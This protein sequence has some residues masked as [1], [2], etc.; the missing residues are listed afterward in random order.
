MTG[1]RLL[2]FLAQWESLFN[3]LHIFAFIVHV[4]SGAIESTTC[5]S[6]FTSMIFNF[7]LLNSKSADIM[8][9]YIF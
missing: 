4:L 2:I 7:S 6:L 5:F 9:F 3:C 1:N 8:S